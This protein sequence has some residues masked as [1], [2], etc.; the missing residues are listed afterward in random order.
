MANRLHRTLFERGQADRFFGGRTGLAH[1]ETVARV[2][3]TDEV[4][5]GSFAAKVAVDAGDVY[6]K[7]AGCVLGDFSGL[8]RHEHVSQKREDK[9][10]RNLVGGS[11]ST[12]TDS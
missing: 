10:E 2:V 9:R 3:L 11:G 6:V 4:V 5:W 7:L 1:D 12:I 8:V